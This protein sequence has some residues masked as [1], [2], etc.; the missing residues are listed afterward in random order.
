MSHFQLLNSDI[1]DMDTACWDLQESLTIHN[2]LI[3][4]IEDDLFVLYCLTHYLTQ[5]FQC[6]IEIASSRELI[7]RKLDQFKF[8]LIISDTTI[9]AD[10]D[11]LTIKQ[12][13]DI[14]EIN[15]KNNKTPLI[16]TDCDE[17][18]HVGHDYWGKRSI[19]ASKA[20]EIIGGRVDSPSS[21]RVAYYCFN[22]L[23]KK[24]VIDDMIDEYQLLPM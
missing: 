15:I 10:Q 12:R 11:L 7:I 9:I 3:L 5:K 24:M 6:R 17:V 2:K 22:F 20:L 21:Q 13:S 16:I 23:V 19:Y 18:R 14:P 4:M 8:D 1:V